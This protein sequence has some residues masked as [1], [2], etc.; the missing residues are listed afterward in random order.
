MTGLTAV[1]LAAVGFLAFQASAN[2]PDHLARP[3]GKPSASDSASPGGHHGGKKKQPTALPADSGSGERVVYALDAHRVWLVSAAG[4]VTRTYQVT[5]STVD[6]EPGT[7]A[8]TSRSSSVA[9]SDGVPIE[10]VVRFT[11]VEGVT[12]GFSAAVDGS[13][14]KPDPQTKTGGIRESRA[15][16]RAM[17]ELATINV[18][19]VVV[20]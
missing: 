15:D 10:H 4:K 3:S 11:S 1:A 8:V 6:P 9:G 13:T 18:K 2:A 17:W 7:Y 14:P 20:P 16:A 19:V 5:P 12:I